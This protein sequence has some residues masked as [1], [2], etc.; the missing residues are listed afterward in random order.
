MGAIFAVAGDVEDR[1]ELVL[2][3]QGLLHQLLAAGVV[4]D[5]GQDGEGLLALEQ[6]LIGVGVLGHGGCSRL[7][8]SRRLAKKL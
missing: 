7:V 5:G 4:I 1:A 6:H 3:G 8:G 2:D